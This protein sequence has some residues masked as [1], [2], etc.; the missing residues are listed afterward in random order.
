MIDHNLAF[1]PEFDASAF[2]DLHVFAGEVRELFSDF[3]LRDSYRTRFAKA[4]ESWPDIYATL[5]DARR[6][7]DAEK[8]APIEYPFEEIKT[9]LDRALTDAF[10]QLPPT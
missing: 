10:W 8:T 2:L 9:Q 4:L 5:P 7:I 6:F 3:L 1:D